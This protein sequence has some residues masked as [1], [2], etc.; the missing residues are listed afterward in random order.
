MEF[1]ASAWP[2]ILSWCGKWSNIARFVLWSYQCTIIYICGHEIITWFE[3]CC[4]F[5][6]AVNCW[7]SVN[8][9]RKSVSV[10]YPAHIHFCSW[11]GITAEL[12]RFVSTFINLCGRRKCAFLFVDFH[13]SDH[14]RINTF[15][16][17]ILCVHLVYKI[18]G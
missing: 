1:T 10:C 4:I 17:V 3:N 16:S 15:V 9:L 14:V 11:F 8:I 5:R 12:L 6:Q 18:N 7:N 2:F 13:S